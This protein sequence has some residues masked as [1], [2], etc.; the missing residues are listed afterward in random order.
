M[1]IFQMALWADFG[2]SFWAEKILLNFNSVVCVTYKPR[3]LYATWGNKDS[4]ALPDSRVGA[5]A[6]K[7][8]AKERFPLQ[9]VYMARCVVSRI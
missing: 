7:T 4:P 5:N 8:E 1:Y 2:A 6:T 9:P 3:R